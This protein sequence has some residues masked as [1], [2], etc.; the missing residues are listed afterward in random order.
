MRSD[1]PSTDRHDDRL[2]PMIPRTSARRSAT[3]VVLA[4]L[5]LAALLGTAH[6]ASARSGD[7]KVAPSTARSADGRTATDGVRTLTVSQVSGLAPAGQ[8]VR[9]T[10]HGY[11]T[12]KGI[13]VALCAVP[14]KD[15]LP[16]PCGG[17]VDME[18]Q[19]GASQWISS[20]PPSYGVGLAKP[21]GPG[22]SFDTTF[23]ISPVISASV[24]CRQVRCAIVTRND[25]SRSSD[26]SQDILVPVAFAAAAAP[27]TPGGG[28]AGSQPAPS[29]KPPQPTAPPTTA[30]PVTTAAPSTTTTTT[31]PP[32]PDSTVSEDGRSVSDGRRTLR[33]S[34][35]EVLDRDGDPVTV[36]GRGF[37]TQRGI[38]VSLCRVDPDTSA[39]GPCASGEGRAAWISSNPPEWG[40]EL[41]EPFG[42]GG[43]FEVDLQMEPGI[44][45]ATDCA[46]DDIECALVVRADDT[47]KDDRSLD[48]ILPVEFASGDA[49]VE[50]V[51]DDDAEREVAPSAAAAAKGG[52]EGSGPGPWL[53]AA[54]LAAVL[55]GGG[56]FWWVRSRRRAPSAPAGALSAT[57]RAGW[58]R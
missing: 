28:G 48:L 50:E 38:Y 44:D 6:P 35:V 24:D 16:S 56:G 43:S 9:V 8:T 7:P 2:R 51:T 53:L 5:A 46:D 54:A 55:A 10:G 33:A 42:D 4:G 29:A 21:Y 49:A 17:G 37:D 19:A 39:P 11:D 25:H 12:N 31:T 27:P 47:A 1:H 26:R 13:Y 57:E 23:R 45:A 30:A 58:S 41:A 36:E 32:A 22:G 14:P 3:L 34:S 15:V 20:N 18:G 52:D 40:R